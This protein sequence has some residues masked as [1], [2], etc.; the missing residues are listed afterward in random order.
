MS[1]PIKFYGVR[2]IK[3]ISSK[4]YDR[5]VINIPS[6]LIKDYKLSQSDNFGVY[7]IGNCIVYEKLDRHTKVLRV[8]VF[9]L[10]NPVT[11][12][13]INECLFGLDRCYPECPLLKKGNCHSKVNLISRFYI[14]VDEYGNVMEVRKADK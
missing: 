10:D 5:F 14:V 12:H 6:D 9:E 4:D 7:Y 1:K 11:R 13:S 2:S 8:D 3:H